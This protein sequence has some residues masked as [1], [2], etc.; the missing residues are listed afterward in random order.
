MFRCPTSILFFLVLVFSW[1]VVAVVPAEATPPT[2]WQDVRPV[3]RKSC[4]VCHNPRQLAEKEISG[5]IALDTYDKVLH[6]IQPRKPAESLLFT[7]LIEKNDERRMPLGAKPLEAEPIALVKAWIEAGAPEGTRPADLPDTPKRPAIVRKQPVR[8]PGVKA[9]LTLPIGPLS[10]VVALD[11]H[12]SKPLLAT[13]CYGR[14]CLWDL[15]Q[16]QPA[17]VLTS[18]L[19]AI[20]DVRFSPDGQLLAVAGG[21]PSAKGDLRL[22]DVATGELR[23]TLAGHEDVVAA[24]AW[25]PD[26][27][28]LASA[29][30]DRT[31]CTWDVS[32]GKRMNIFTHHSDFVLC[33]AYS[34]DGK[35]LL[36]GSKDRSVRVLD[37]ETGVSRFTLGDRDEEV[38]ALRLSPDGKSLAVSGAQPFLSWWNLETGAKLRAVN[39]HRGAVNALAFDNKANRL[40]SG[41]EDST[42]R[43]WNGSSGAALTSIPVGSLVYSV[44]VAPNGKLLATGSFDG[45]TRVY[46]ASGKL[47]ATL[48]D[49]ESGWLIRTA[50][51][52]T[53]GT[54]A[55]LKKAQFTL[56]GKP[57]DALPLLS[58]DAVRRSFSSLK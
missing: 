2:Y 12:P 19:G 8:L 54:E 32:T 44:A 23:Q 55:L 27:K 7:L 50:E 22:F 26:S 30:Y 36:T 21:Q 5:G 48:I 58:A 9:D 28:R 11:F 25:R 18:V 3:L 17:R 57:V 42:L 46:D 29:S 13:A 1:A 31:A 14:V 53:T 49:A 16:A 38:L 43:F 37:A 40:I 35:T 51:G 52:Q 6:Y 56:A 4:T 45:L 39:G 15:T 47:L 33:V 20:N 34:P 41:G 24:I 10:P